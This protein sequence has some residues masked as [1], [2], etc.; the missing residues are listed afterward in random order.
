[1]K[2]PNISCNAGNIFPN[3]LKYLREP[4]YIRQSGQRKI[5]SIFDDVE[6]RKLRANS[7]PLGG[8]TTRKSPIKCAYKGSYR[9]RGRVSEHKTNAN[10]HTYGEE[11]TREHNR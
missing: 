5:C 2:L 9:K 4:L 7:I 8:R 1:M 3:S 11:D 10:L 6:S